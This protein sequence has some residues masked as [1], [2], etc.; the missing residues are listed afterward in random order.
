MGDRTPVLSVATV[1]LSLLALAA[2]DLLIARSGPYSAATSG[3]HLVLLLITF[4]LSLAP[5]LLALSLA[6]SMRWA[7][8]LLLALNILLVGVGFDGL[9]PFVAPIV[10]GVAAQFSAARSA[11]GRN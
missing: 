2:S 5:G 4:V 11:L 3:R 7:A 8:A 9:M 10:T 6:H 1:V